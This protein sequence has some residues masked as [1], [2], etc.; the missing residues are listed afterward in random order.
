MSSLSIQKQLCERLERVYKIA[1]TYRNLCLELIP[2]TIEELNNRYVFE[3][4]CIKRVKY[5]GILADLKDQYREMFNHDWLRIMTDEEILRAKAK[6]YTREK[7]KS[8]QETKREQARKMKDKFK[9]E[10]EADI[11]AQDKMYRKF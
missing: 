7:L 6:I 2:E 5:S 11:R 4:I 3:T 1:S 10:S 9:G 8:E